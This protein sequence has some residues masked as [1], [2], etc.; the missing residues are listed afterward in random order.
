MQAF[1]HPLRHCWTLPAPNRRIL[2]TAIPGG[3]ER[4]AAT[5]RNRWPARRWAIRG[6]Q[7][8]IGRLLFGLFSVGRV[9]VQETGPNNH[10]QSLALGAGT[11]RPRRAA[12]PRHA[13]MCQRQSDIWGGPIRLDSI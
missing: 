5:Q 12:D 13:G 3:G 8:R 9:Q 4:A 10:R 7:S 2:Q 6:Q 11:G 1:F